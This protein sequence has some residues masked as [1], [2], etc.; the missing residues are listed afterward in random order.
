MLAST[1]LNLV[2]AVYVLS[3]VS[4]VY[5]QPIHFP[6]G[7]AIKK[8][9]DSLFDRIQDAANGVFYGRNQTS[10]SDASESTSSTLFS[11]LL[12]SESPSSE[13][14]QSSTTS[15]DEG[16]N[17]NN[18]ENSDNSIESDDRTSRFILVVMAQ[19]VRTITP[20]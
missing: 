12:T 17:S 4:T 15:Q 13:D 3:F 7:N 1:N 18:G 14:V 11:E 8:R 10:S 2:S 20:Q 16:R 6:Q 19:L 9:A 5:G